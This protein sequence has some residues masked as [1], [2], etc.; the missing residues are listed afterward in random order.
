MAGPLQQ[1]LFGLAGE[2]EAAWK[3]HRRGAAAAVAAGWF[4][5]LPGSSVADNIHH[6][7]HVSRFF[8]LCCS[9]V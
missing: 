6:Y 3:A 5:Y 4:D 9:S 1:L 7:L 2:A 8:C